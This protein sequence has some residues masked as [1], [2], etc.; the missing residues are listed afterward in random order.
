MMF[1]RYFECV[2]FSDFLN[3]G[4]C[5]GHPFE[6]RRLVDA[7]QMITHNIKACVVG[8]HLNCIDLSM[9]FK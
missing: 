5:C 4:I 8:T 6:L 9:Q 1:M 3:K 7:I 2:L